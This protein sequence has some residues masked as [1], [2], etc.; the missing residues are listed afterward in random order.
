MEVSNLILDCLEKIDGQLTL[1]VNVYGD[2]N[3]ENLN[4]GRLTAGEVKR[5]KTGASKQRI[6]TATFKYR[7][8][9]SHPERV[10]LLY[11]ALLKAKNEG[12]SEGWIAQDTRPDDFMKLFTGEPT[13]VQVRWTG[14]KQHLKYLFVLLLQKGFIFAPNESR[15]PWVIVQSHF[16]PSLGETFSDWDK[17]KEPIRFRR[18]IEILAEILNS[19]VDVRELLR[20]RDEGR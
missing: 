12:R 20:L 3:A 13:G 19:E 16:V 11:Q 9:E 10:G 2:L 15:Q 8:M 14:T 4:V 18:T 1:I 5:K 17:E 7:W 6:V